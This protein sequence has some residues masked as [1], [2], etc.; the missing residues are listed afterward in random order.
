MTSDCFPRSYE[1]PGPVPLM[2]S[3]SVRRRRQGNKPPEERALPKG[4]LSTG[5]LDLMA[6]DK[7]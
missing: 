7:A 3:L 2:S 4:A 5:S 6:V 1:L